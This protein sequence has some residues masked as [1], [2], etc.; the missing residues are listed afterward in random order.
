[1]NNVTFLSVRAKVCNSTSSAIELGKKTGDFSLAKS[2]LK[3]KQDSNSKKSAAAHSFL[4][5][6]R[7]ELSK[8]ASYITS[9]NFRGEP[10]TYAATKGHNAQMD[11]YSSASYD[12][13]QAKAKVTKYD[14]RQAQLQDK[15]RQL[16]N[17]QFEKAH[18]IHH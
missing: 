12:L 18:N 16:F 15:A 13:K 1:M 10:K 5:Q 4:N 3:V 8:A 17:A 9:G 11:R 14:E 7:E 2:M 6:A